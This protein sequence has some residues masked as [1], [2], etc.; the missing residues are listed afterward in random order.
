MFFTSV[1]SKEMTASFIFIYAF[2]FILVSVSVLHILTFNNSLLSR[3]STLTR[4]IDI[5][6]AI[7][8][9]RPSVCPLRSDILWKLFNVLS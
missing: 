2:M 8:S 9:V 5:D 1:S 4:D 7:L 6:I 3:V